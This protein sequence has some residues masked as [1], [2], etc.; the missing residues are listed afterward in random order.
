MDFGGAG[1]LTGLSPPPCPSLGNFFFLG[2]R[3]E[4]ASFVSLDAIRQ[5]I[6]GTSIK[7]GAQN[8]Y[9]KKKGLI[10]VRFLLLC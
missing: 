4:G 9:F 2:N 5:L 3:L 10:P 6:Q 8:L 7:L 1:T